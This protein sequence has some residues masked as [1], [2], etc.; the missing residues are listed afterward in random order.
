MSEAPSFLPPS[1]GELHEFE[2]V[3]L[4]MNGVRQS[5]RLQ[6]KQPRNALVSFDRAIKRHGRI[7]KVRKVC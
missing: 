1:N 7:L 5:Y 4:D 6:S 3:Y 2:V